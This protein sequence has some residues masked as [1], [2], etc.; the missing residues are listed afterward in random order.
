MAILTFEEWF[1]RHCDDYEDDE[2]VDYEYEYQSYI[3]DYQDYQYE[4]YRDSLLWE[5]QDD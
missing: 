2:E 1:D 5:N 4:R 3:S